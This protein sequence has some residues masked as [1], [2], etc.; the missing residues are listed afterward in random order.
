[1]SS[2]KKVMDVICHHNYKTFFV[3]FLFILV[4][5]FLLAHLIGLH[6]KSAKIE[7]V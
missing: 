2:L 5:D 7:Y 6:R 4:I 1:M 3:F